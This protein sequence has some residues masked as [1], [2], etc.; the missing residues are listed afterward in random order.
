[1]VISLIFT[2]NLLY[3]FIFEQYANLFQKI[4]NSIQLYII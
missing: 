4:K 2:E 3:R 1:M